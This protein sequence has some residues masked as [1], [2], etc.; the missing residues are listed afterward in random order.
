MPADETLKSAASEA[1]G[2][3]ADLLVR[4]LGVPLSF[5]CEVAPP[6]PRPRAS[7][8]RLL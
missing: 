7:R 6:P 8:P 1:V 4:E 3:M 2:E 5:E